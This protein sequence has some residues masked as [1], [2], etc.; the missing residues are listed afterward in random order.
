MIFA[1]ALSSTAIAGIQPKFDSYMKR[2]TEIIELLEKKKASLKPAEYN[3]YNN[4]LE[5]SRQKMYNGAGSMNRLEYYTFA[6][7]EFGKLEAIEKK[8]K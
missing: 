3:K 2:Y 4:E 5:T 1:T 6:D 8:I 7:N